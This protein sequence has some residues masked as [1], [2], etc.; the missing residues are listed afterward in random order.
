VPPGLLA[1]SS[2]ACPSPSSCDAVGYR[3]GG[4]A[5]IRLR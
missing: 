5:I 4:A 1:L 3:Q 2:I